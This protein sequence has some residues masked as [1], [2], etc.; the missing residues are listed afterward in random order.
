MKQKRGYNNKLDALLALVSCDLANK[1]GNQNRE[2]TRYYKKGN[3]FFLTSSQEES[4]HGE[5]GEGD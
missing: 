5:E 1:R 4:P 3:K 2:E